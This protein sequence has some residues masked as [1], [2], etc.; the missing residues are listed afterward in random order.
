MKIKSIRTKLL[1]AFIILTFTPL[2]ISGIIN[3][4]LAKNMIQKQ[5][6]SEL[7][8]RRG[9]RCETFKLIGSILRLGLL[10]TPVVRFERATKTNREL[11]R[12]LLLMQH[13]A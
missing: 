12:P 11:G 9:F 6:R 5:I 10:T 4:I 2:L 1:L 8:K 13:K 3:F 7:A